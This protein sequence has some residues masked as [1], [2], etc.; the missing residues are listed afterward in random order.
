MGAPLPSQPP[1]DPHEDP[2]V[3]AVR[4]THTSVLL[5]APPG[6]PVFLWTLRRC[7]SALRRPRTTCTTPSW[8]SAAM[9][10][11]SRVSV[12]LGTPHPCP[13]QLGDTLTPDTVPSPGNIETNHNLPPSHKSRNNLIR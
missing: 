11:P 3:Q 2:C 6:T 4:G 8:P 13:W 5:P 9:A 10:S 12:G 7:G 1:P